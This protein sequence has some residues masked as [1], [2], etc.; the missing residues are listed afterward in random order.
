MRPRS[1]LAHA[2]LLVLAAPAPSTAAE[3][4][5]ESAALADIVVTA[6]KR[7]ARLQ[8]VPLSITAL[9]GDE[10][11][12]SGALRIEDYVGSVPGL[13]FASNGANSGVLSIRGIS[14]SS[15]AGNTQSPVALYYDD[16]PALDPFA[17]LTVPDLQL[18]DVERVEVLRGPQGTLFGSGAMG[19]AIHVQTR[20]P[21]LAAF[22]GQVEIDGVSTSHGGTGGGASAALNLPIVSGTL[23]A[24]LV[25]FGRREPGFV[26]SARYGSK[27]ID[28]QDNWGGRVRLRWQP[29]DSLT[30][31]ASARIEDARPDDAPYVPYGS[32]RPA[33]QAF[34]PQPVPTRVTTYALDVRYELPDVSFTSVTHH[35]ERQ[36]RLARDFTPLIAALLG[37]L[38]VNGPAPVT[39]EGPSRT[40]GQ[41]F[42]VASSGESAIQWLVGAIYLDN[43]RIDIERLVVP[44]AGALL[45]PIG[46]PS[47]ALFATDS[48]IDITEKALF[49]EVSWRFAPRWTAT[50]GART[51]RNTL[52]V[53]NR[54]D[55][56]INGGP[57]ALARSKREHATTPKFA[58]TFAPSADATIYVQA[59]KGYRVGQNNLSPASDPASGQPIPTGYGP[60]SLWNYELGAKLTS[61]DRRYRVAAAVYRIDW[62]DIQLQAAS[63]SGFAYIANAGRARSNG[64]ELEL[65]ARPLPG[66]ELALAASHVDTKLTRVPSNV[67]ALAGDPLPGSAKW[68]IGD[69][70][71][72]TFAPDVNGYLRLD[73]RYVGRTYSDL[74]RPTAL[75][76]GNY[77]VVNLRLGAR[78]FGLDAAVHVDNAADRFAYVSAVRIA[79]TANAVPLRPR[80]IGVSFACEF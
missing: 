22:G 34:V 31:D 60:D 4:P 19:G 68:S 54:A 1:P 53:D 7:E 74:N 73:H 56:I 17:P 61:P 5:P 63:A 39:A 49:G 72:W 67:A 18:F 50:A 38:G 46:F 11:Q 35:N 43:E 9:T 42:R 59:A 37:P 69:Y 26:D 12:R 66:L 10:L 6:T 13:A 71:T 14:T 76:Y 36:G 44:G 20:A 8:D 51:F 40:F 24:R 3:S 15:L 70:A 2:I 23:A 32:T 78:L 57:S 52:A 45:A 29:T 65:A 80:T 58:L 25:A 77:H 79:G 75:A 28:D 33:S 21:D 47:D 62:S 48:V 64:V 30:L 55:G 41:E 27:D 16:V